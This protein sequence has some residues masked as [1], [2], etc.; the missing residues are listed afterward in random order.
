MPK[1]SIAPNLERQRPLVSRK[2]KNVFSDEINLYL[3]R[4]L[5]RESS[6]SDT[7]GQ[8]SDIPR[9]LQF[10]LA[11]A[12]RQQILPW[13]WSILLHTFLLILLALSLF[14]V[15]RQEPIDV[16]SN[17]V[18]IPIQQE[19]QVNVG[20]AEGN[21]LNVPDT[22]QGNAPTT[23]ETAA[24]KI[25]LPH[26]S[27]GL[28]V[29]GRDVSKRAAIQGGV[30]GGGQT[31]EAVLAGLRWL[32]K[33]QQPNGAWHFSG[34]FPQSAAKRLEDDHAA[35]AMA[36]L[37]FQG[38]GV[39][40]DSHHPQLIEFVQPVRRGWEWLL[41]QQNPDGSFVSPSAKNTN[42]FYTHGFCTIA[43]CELLAM[44]GGEPFREPAQR[45][46]DYCVRHQSLRRGGWRYLPD[47]FSDQSDMSV[48]G[49]IVLALKSGES[50]GL[51]VPPETYIKVMKLL[52]SMMVSN[53]YKYRDEEPEPRI[54]MTAEALLCRILLGWRRSDPRL[55]AGVQFI[56]D[57]PPSFADHYQR[58]VYYWFFAAQTLHYYGGNEWQTWNSM[59]REQLLQHQEQFGAEVGSWNPLQPVRDR[60]G[61]HYGR[62]YTTCMSL[63]ILEMD[64]Q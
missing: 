19:A 64:S 48:T 30:G 35:T 5:H 33:V 47:R 38:Y 63:Y 45:G 37:A 49:W 16:L 59:I 43:L 36:L 9:D 52:D 14:P 57:T 20:H 54:S 10:E 42:R 1:I 21:V 32:V 23:E 13:L 44:T 61:M 60:W 58:D 2:R 46:I 29:L 26:P 8:V 27:P 18:N 55:A 15:I 31:D 11:A 12:I 7:L 25:E 40:P 24:P 34:S 28:Y 22:S 17:M 56:L 41:R 3:L 62:L 53:Q 51:T 6:L 50:V 4:L 39:T